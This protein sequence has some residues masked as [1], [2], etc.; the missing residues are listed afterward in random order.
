M[1]DI[2][3]TSATVSGVH[4]VGVSLIALGSFIT[5]TLIPFIVAAI[6]K[7]VPQEMSIAWVPIVLGVI[8]WIGIGLSQGQ[9]TNWIN[10]LSYIM[11]G[12]ANGGIASSIRDIFKGK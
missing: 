4:V 3:L 6:K 9:V 8:L 7:F 10:L 11:V 1:F 5:V 12:I 2:F